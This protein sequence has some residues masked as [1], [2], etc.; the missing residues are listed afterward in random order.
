MTLR[1]KQS[2]FALLLAQLI[3]WIDSKGWA[4]TLA[5][6]GVGELRKVQLLGVNGKPTGPKMQALDRVHMKGSLHYSRL[7]ADLNLFVNGKWIQSG[8]HPAWTAIGER[9]ES[10]DPLCRWG[11]RFA[12]SNHVSL[13]HGG[14]A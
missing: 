14:K 2:L 7:A 1:E 4:V 3:V 5:D 12:D 11:G 10:L 9:W 6:V 8:S 13:A